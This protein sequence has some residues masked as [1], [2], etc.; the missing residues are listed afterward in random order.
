MYFL[1]VVCRFVLFK[2]ES[3]TTIPELLLQAFLKEPKG[4]T[5]KATDIE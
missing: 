3:G 5:R 4:V 2:K 1:G